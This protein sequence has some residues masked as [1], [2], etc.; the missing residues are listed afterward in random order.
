MFH[1]SPTEVFRLFSTDS[2]IISFHE[3]KIEFPQNFGYNHL[4]KLTHLSLRMIITI[5]NSKE[6]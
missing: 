5:K 3:K 1:C 2:I 4:E 6:Y